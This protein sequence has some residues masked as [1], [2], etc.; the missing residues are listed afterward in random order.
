MNMFFMYVQTLIYRYVHWRVFA[1][2]TEYS[3]VLTH[4]EVRN[5]IYPIRLNIIKSR[6]ILFSRQP[7]DQTNRR[8]QM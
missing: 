7:L 3:P 5:S 1:V 6:P 4:Q 2:L 8:A